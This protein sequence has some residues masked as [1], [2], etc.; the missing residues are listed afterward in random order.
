M[1]GELFNLSAES[2]AQGRNEMQKLIEFKNLM[3]TKIN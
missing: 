2:V 3:V 1:L